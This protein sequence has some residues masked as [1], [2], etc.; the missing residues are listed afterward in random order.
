MNS[1]LRSAKRLTAFMAAAALASGRSSIASRTNVLKAKKT[2][3][4]TAQPRAVVRSRRVMDPVNA[5]RASLGMAQTVGCIRDRLG[6]VAVL[7][8]ADAA[9]ALERRAE[10]ER[11]RVADLVGDRGDRRARLQE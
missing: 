10:R 5:T 3:A 9:Q 8:R 11:R 2:P 4:L 1:G 7:A 6:R